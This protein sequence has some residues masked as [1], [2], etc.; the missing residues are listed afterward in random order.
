MQLKN[1]LIIIVIILSVFS[2]EKEITTSFSEV[3]FTSVKNDMVLV[4]I[5]KANGNTTVS[6]HINS[7]I[8]RTVVRS[9]TP[10]NENIDDISIEESI[11]GFETSYSSFINDF[12]ESKQIWEIQIDSDV[13]YQSDEIISIAITS[14]K[15]TGGA[16]GNLVITLINFD[17]QTGYKIPNQDL[18]K[19]FEDFKGIAKI[20]FD[21]TIEDPNIL[22]DSSS[23]RLPE[24]MGY[25][26]EGLL[27]LYNTYEIAPYSS[28]TIEFTIPFEKL[29]SLL[30][31]NGLQ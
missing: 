7:E 3:K 22:F 26:E 21:K 31:F 12:P 10:K 17:A 6:E 9:I 11:G 14:Y 18:F 28:G 30:V 29:E 27:L 4:N 2:C 19:D 1:H 25:T 13:M 15:N 8:K 24:N 20:N 16:H 23:F 5:P